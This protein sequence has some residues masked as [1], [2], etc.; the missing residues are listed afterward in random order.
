MLLSHELRTPLQAMLGWVQVL[1]AGPREEGTIGYGLDAIERNIRVQARVIDDLLEMAEMLPD[2]FVLQR[3]PVPVSA[4]L[5]AALQGIAP[6]AAAKGIRL[7]RNVPAEEEP[8]LVDPERLQRAIQVLLSQ[9]LEFTAA[10]GTIQ[11]DFTQPGPFG[12]IVVTDRSSAKDPDAAP[13]F[14]EFRHG[15]P[16]S[17]TEFGPLGIGLGNAQ[18][19][20]EIHGGEV[21]AESAGF[22]Q[23]ATF[24]L[25]LPRSA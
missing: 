11:V 7:S 17:T 6:A 19:L 15:P 5:D 22:G 3:R 21:R 10:G 18:K 20:V 8:M 9:S 13:I 4:L 1:R 24:T 25:S 14:D 23:G 12:V 16:S 2:A